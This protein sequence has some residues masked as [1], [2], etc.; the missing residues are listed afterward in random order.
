MA[1]RRRNIDPA[2][3]HR[4]WGVLAGQV[5]GAKMIARV[6]MDAME[7]GR[8]DVFTQAITLSVT[9]QDPTPEGLPN[10]EEMNRLD[11]IEQRVHDVIREV[12][13]AI[14]A[15]LISTGGRREI[16]LYSRDHGWIEEHRDR[17]DGA[18]GDHAA[19]VVVTT[20]PTWDFY[21]RFRQHAR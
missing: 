5:D 16:V 21:R 17:L 15:M 4:N 18:I 2:L 8:G 7:D 10:M 11:Q 12:G 14:L 9:I 1:E 13:G 19:R 6:R 20:D 3:D